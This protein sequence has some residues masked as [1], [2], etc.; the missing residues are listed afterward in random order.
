MNKTLTS[1]ELQKLAVDYPPP[2]PPLSTTFQRLLHWAQ[3][4][5]DHQQQLTPVHEIEYW[6]ARKMA[7]ASLLKDVFNLAASDPQLTAAGLASS[8]PNDIMRFFGMQ[9]EAL[10]Y[11]TCDCGGFISNARMARRIRDYALT[12]HAPPTKFDP[13]IRTLRVQNVPISF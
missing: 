13:P 9:M 8:A 1:E 7:T 10:H 11:I 5:D 2:P 3:L 4:I 6:S 12:F